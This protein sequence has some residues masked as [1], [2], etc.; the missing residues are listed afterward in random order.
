MVASVVLVGRYN[1]EIANN[2]I[3]TPDGSTL[4]LSD[5]PFIR[6]RFNEYT[7][8]YMEYIA[9]M[10]NKFLCVHLTEIRL[11]DNS[12]EYMNK[13]QNLSKRIA[14]Y[15]YIPIDDTVV[16]EGFSDSTLELIVKNINS[17]SIIDGIQLK[18]ESTSLQEFAF[19]ALKDMLY[20]NIPKLKKYKIG[21]CG[22]PICFSDGNACLTAVKAREILAKYSIYDDVVVPSSNHEVRIENIDEYTNKCGCIRYYIYDKDVNVPKNTNSKVKSKNSSDNK[23]KIPK[24][25]GYISIDW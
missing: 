18:D 22:G 13:I 1:I 19:D 24:A 9:N 25:K 12:I 7:D 17:G 8:E 20:T 14:K 5:I 3:G 6:Y 15:L 23:V 2:K 4:N 11:S 21:V 16:K 10:M